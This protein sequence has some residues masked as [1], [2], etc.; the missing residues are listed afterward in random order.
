MGQGP[1]TCSSIQKFLDPNMD[2]DLVQPTFPRNAILK[3]QT[4]RVAGQLFNAIDG[5]P[6]STNPAANC[7]IGSGTSSSN[8]CRKKTKGNLCDTNSPP[9][10]VSG[11]GNCV[12]FRNGTGGWSISQVSGVTPTTIITEVPVG[13]FLCMGAS[14]EMV[15]VAKKDDLGTTQFKERPYCLSD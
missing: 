2:I 14:N 7:S 1:V 8:C 4:I 9:G 3:G 12:A 11:G 13:T 5:N 10:P 15:R 6:R